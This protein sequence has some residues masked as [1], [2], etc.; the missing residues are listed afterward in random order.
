MWTHR[1]PN[2]FFSFIQIVELREREKE[3]VGKGWSLKGHLM[4]NDGTALW[5]ACLCNKIFS[6]QSSAIDSIQDFV[7]MMIVIFITF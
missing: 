5:V 6:L 1:Q 2:I 4:Y 7:I 3:G